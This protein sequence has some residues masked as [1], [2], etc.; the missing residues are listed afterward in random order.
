MKRLEK[1][2]LAAVSAG[3]TG[4]LCMMTVFAEDTTRDGTST[5]GWTSIIFLIL[6]FV[7]LYFI[8]IR[9]QRKKDK[10]TKA[11]Q[12]SLQ[13]GDEVVTIGG[14]I[15]LVV[16]VSEDNVV[17]ETTGG[18]NKI[19]LKSWAIQ[20]NVTVTENA[21]RAQEEKVAAAKAKQEEKAEKK[22]KKKN[23][24]SDSAGDGILKD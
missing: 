9:P 5:S 10:E 22:K 12:R 2:M 20:E 11:M 6:M 1:L 17:I 19:R 7:V 3:L 21:K 23:G 15:G 13:V 8:M 4:S 24:D 16:K 18:A 14:I